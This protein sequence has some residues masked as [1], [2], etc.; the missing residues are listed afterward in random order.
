[1]RIPVEKN[2]TGNEHDVYESGRAFSVRKAF[3]N[4]EP[5]NARMMYKQDFV[6]KNKKGERQKQ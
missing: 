4:A 5:V 3:E 2:V 6:G 1:M